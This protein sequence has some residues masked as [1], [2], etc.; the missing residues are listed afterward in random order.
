[1][2]SARGKDDE[3]EALDAGGQ[4]RHDLEHDPAR[5][6]YLLNEPGVGYRLEVT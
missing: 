4:L 3:I 6:Q 5:P 2:L 1:V